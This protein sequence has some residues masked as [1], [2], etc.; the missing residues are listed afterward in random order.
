MELVEANSEVHLS[1][2][3]F[4]ISVGDMRVNDT[5]ININ[6][7]PSGS[8]TTTTTVTQMATAPCE[9]HINVTGRTLEYNAEINGIYEVESQRF[10]GKPHYM[11]TTKKHHL[12]W[13]SQHRVWAIGPT[14]GS[15]S[16]NA[17]ADD[18]A[19]SPA[20]IRAHFIVFN[21]HTTGGWITDTS[22]AALCYTAA[23]PDLATTTT[24]TVAPSNDSTEAP[25]MAAGDENSSHLVFIIA[26]FVT[27]VVLLI[28]VAICKRRHTRQRRKSEVFTMVSINRTSPVPGDF[29]TVEV[30]PAKDTFL[31]VPNVGNVVSACRKLASPVYG[32]PVYCSSPAYCI[33]G[34]KVNCHANDN[35][36][37]YDYCRE[38][39][40]TPTSDTSSIPDEEIE[41]GLKEYA[42]IEGVVE[43]E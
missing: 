21:G 19:P 6:F 14:L 36:H 38:E 27:L 34:V 2:A 25:I 8:S 39:S 40:E 35:D 4:T 13:I 22:I 30:T 42:G 23:A 16:I 41:L 31:T 33:P 1:S 7:C 26:L 5:T 11:Q 17:Y 28:V 43:V 32:S 20:E 3:G 10:N 9:S 12:Y 15:L 29:C 24:Q 37:I 18:N